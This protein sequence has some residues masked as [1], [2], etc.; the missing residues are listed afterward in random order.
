[1][2]LTRKQL[3]LVEAIRW[4]WEEY[5]IGPTYRELAEMLNTTPGT[6]FERVLKLEKMGVV[7][8]NVGKSR[9]IRVVEDV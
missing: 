8:T 4:F 5:N 9:S 1:M 6:M 2:E 7:K 3:M